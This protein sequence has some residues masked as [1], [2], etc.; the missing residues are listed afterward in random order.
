M[1]DIILLVII[2]FVSVVLHEIAHGWA[3][4]LLGDPTARMAGRLTLNPLKHIDPLGTFLVPA[5]LK[6]MGF[7]PI[8]WAKPVPVN[9]S[10]LRVPK[11]DMLWV[12]LAGPA[13][14]IGIALLSSVL[15]RFAPGPF[16]RDLLS[17]VILLNLLLAAFN[18]VPV[19]PLDGSRIVMGLLPMRWM[20][21]YAQLEPIG[22]L[23]VFAG[24]NLG[25][26]DFLWAGVVRW[27]LKLG[28][29]V[30]AI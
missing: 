29:N 20:R 16:F 17:V 24:L 30:S 10:N 27:G 1:G 8:G 5:L 28:V 19:P 22:L 25:L 12:A 6:L 4:Y 13:A 3:A 7:S 23:I 18:L 9:F 2:V 15:L 26:L 21:R 11:R 14:N